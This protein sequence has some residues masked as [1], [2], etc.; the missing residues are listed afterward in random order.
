MTIKLSIKKDP[1]LV[2]MDSLKI[3]DTFLHGTSLGVICEYG[4][5]K[6]C[7]ICWLST[8]HIT[9]LDE[10]ALVEAVELEIKVITK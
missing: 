5:H 3:G 2:R 6:Y 8:A 4:V 9:S 10:G 7:R 1:E